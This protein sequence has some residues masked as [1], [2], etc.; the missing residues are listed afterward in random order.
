MMLI[1]R[2]REIA[3]QMWRDLK[4]SAAEN[5][6]RDRRADVESFENLC[7]EDSSAEMRKWSQKRVAGDLGSS[8]QGGKAEVKAEVKENLNI[9]TTPTPL[10]AL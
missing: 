5:R 8:G 10:P 4:S 3:N 2:M 6:K 7:N 1:E 9:I